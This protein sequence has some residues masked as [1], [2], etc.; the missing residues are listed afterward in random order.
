MSASEEMCSHSDAQQVPGPALTKRATPINRRASMFA[1][2]NHPDRCL[3]RTAA[4]NPLCNASQCVHSG[5]ACSLTPQDGLQRALYDGIGLCVRARVTAAAGARL[6]CVAPPYPNA[7]CEHQHA[8]RS[9]ES[10][11]LYIV[12]RCAA[13]HRKLVATHHSYRAWRALRTRRTPAPVRRA[14]RAANTCA[15]FHRRPGRSWAGL[16]C[17]GALPPAPART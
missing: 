16:P 10:T 13:G 17:L 11:T 3:G 5:C 7:A 1:R 4:W 6:T 15:A 8:Y 14:R 12:M 9:T 2:I